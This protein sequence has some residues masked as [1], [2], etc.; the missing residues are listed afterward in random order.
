M[1]NLKNKYILLI[2]FL[3]EIDFKIDPLG[4]LL[5]NDSRGAILILLTKLKIDKSKFDLLFSKTSEMGYEYKYVDGNKISEFQIF[6]SFEQFHQNISSY[7]KTDNFIVFSKTE[8]VFLGYFNEKS[9]RAEQEDKNIVAFDNVFNYKNFVDM[10]VNLGSLSNT[11]NESFRFIDYYNSQNQTFL[12]SS[13]NDRAILHKCMEFREFDT[14]LLANYLLFKDAIEQDSKGQLSFFMKKEILEESNKFESKIGLREI[15]LNFE[16][17]YDKASINFQIYLND[18][19]IDKLKGEYDNFKR[20]YLSFFSEIISKIVLKILSLPIAFGA[21]IIALTNISNDYLVVLLFL[22]LLTSSIAINISL[23]NHFIDLKSIGTLLVTKTKNIREHKF[24]RSNPAEKKELQEIVNH[25]KAKINI[26]INY[27]W[28]Y[29]G[30]SIILLLSIF[31]FPVRG[32]FYEMSL[33]KKF[34]IEHLELK[35][36]LIISILVI[37]ITHIGIIFFRKLKPISAEIQ[38]LKKDIKLI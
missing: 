31:I 14:P 16:R 23:Y 5:L 3:K 25:I 13:M 38:I 15:F 30:I 10:W 35:D 4:N 18:I 22:V 2:S 11:T 6:E 37:F 26:A 8:D 9:Y 7:K 24:F 1:K 19:S 36:Y 27:I 29:F 21:S 32:I 17:I 33:F 20:E 28:Y 34:S 12:L